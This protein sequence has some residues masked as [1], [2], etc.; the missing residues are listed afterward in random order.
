M[1]LSLG[2]LSSS[3]TTTRRPGRAAQAAAASLY[4]LTLVESESTE[5]CQRVGGV[6]FAGAREKVRHSVETKGHG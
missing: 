2:K 4:R 6:E 3:V 5:G 1:Y